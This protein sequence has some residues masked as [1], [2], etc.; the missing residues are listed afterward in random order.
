M[1]RPL[2][3]I[4][5]TAAQH[6]VNPLESISARGDKPPSPDPAGAQGTPVPSRVSGANYLGFPPARTSSTEPAEP[7]TGKEL[8]ALQLL[9]PCGVNPE[10]RVF[11]ESVLHGPVNPCPSVL[12]GCCWHLAL[13]SFE[14]FGWVRV[15]S[16]PSCSSLI[17]SVY[18]LVK[19]F[20]QAPRGIQI[21]LETRYAL[22]TLKDL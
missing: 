3:A 2:N 19:C 15:H 13:G 1:Y 22:L 9:G 18:D 20:L 16:Q 21:T 6:K 7:R 8:R 11:P 14:A 17:R 10:H 4:H 5:A 12:P